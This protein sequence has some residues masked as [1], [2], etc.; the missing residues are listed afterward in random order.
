MTSVLTLVGDFVLQGAVTAR[1]TVIMK[2]VPPD[3]GVLERV[4]AT[5]SALITV[6]L[7]T[8]TIFI[9][10]GLVFATGVYSWWKRR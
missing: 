3:R 6:V 4:T 8:L 7:L 1:D 10:P 9:I 5:A 2:T